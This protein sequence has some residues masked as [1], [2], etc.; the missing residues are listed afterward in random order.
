MKELI[1]LRKPREKH[2][3]NEDGTITLNMYDEDIHYKKGNEYVEIDNNLIESNNKVVNKENDFKVEFSKDKFLVNITEEENY[4]NIS[5]NDEYHLNDI[6][7]KDNSIIYKN[8]LS[9]I[10]IKYDIVGKTAKETIIVNEQISNFSKVNFLINTNLEL[11]E[12]ENNI[13]AL[14]GNK[15]IVYKFVPPYMIDDKQVFYKCTYNLEKLDNGYLLSLILDEEWLNNASYPVLIDPTIMGETSGVYDTYIYSGD[16]SVD[17]NSQEYLKI[18]VD[19]NNVKYRALVKFDLPIIGTGS[20]VISAIACFNSYKNDYYAVGTDLTSI[21]KKATVHQV[22]QSWDESS[23]NWNTMSEK[24]NSTVENYLELRRGILTYDT[25][26]KGTVTLTQNEVDITNLVKKWYSGVA[27]YGIMLKWLNE[28]KDSNCKEYYLYSKDNKAVSSNILTTDPKPF[29]VIQ[30]RNQTGILDY[31]TYDTVGLTAGSSNVNNYNGNV[32][33]TFTVNETVGGNNPLKLGLVYNTNDVILNND[34]NIALGFKINYDERLTLKT[35]N[36]ENDYIEYLAGDG[37]INYFYLDT[38]DDTYK[39]EDGL[40]LTI[41]KEED[42]YLMEDKNGNKYYFKLNDNIYYL[43]QVVLTNDNTL[44]IIR[45]IN[46]RV[47]EIQNN[48]DDRIAITYGDNK[49]EFESSNEHTYVTLENNKIKTICINSGTI[50]INYND[51]NIISEIIDVTNLKVSYQYYDTI[52]YRLM[53]ITQYGLNNEEGKSKT[54]E[55][56]FNATTITNNTNQKM[57]F[58]FN[59]LGNTIGTVL[60]S[61]D[62]TLKNSYGFSENYVNELK[63]ND[64]NK[65]IESSVPIKYGENLIKNGNFET[66]EDNGFITLRENVMARS[67]NYAALIDQS[68]YGEIVGSFCQDEEYVFSAYFKNATK[69]EINLSGTTFDKTVLLNNKIILPNDDYTRYEIPFSIPEEYMS[70]ISI[71]IFVDDNGVAYMDDIQLEKGTVAS[72]FN[73]LEN[74]NFENNLNGWNV[75]SYNPEDE[76][77]LQNPCEVV[78]LDSGEKAL[79]FNSNPDYSVI[80]RK[81]LNMNGKKGDTYTL[82]FWYKNEGVLDTDL[83]FIGNMATVS[84]YDSTKDEL[85]SEDGYGT[86]NVTLNYHADEWQFFTETFIATSDYDTVDLTIFSIYEANNLLVTNMSLVKNLGSYY[87]VYDEDGNIISSSD[88]ANNKI[89]YKYDTN[90]QLISMFNPKGNNYKYEYDNVIT[91]RL[92]RGISP[93]G[94]SNEIEYDLFGNPIKTIINNVSANSDTNVFYIR[95]KGTKKYLTPNME[96]NLLEI[97]DF[98][99]NRYAFK[100]INS[101]D[102]YMLFL[103]SLSDYCV[104]DINDKLMVVKNG[105]AIIFNIINN[106]NGSIS[107]KVK[108]QELYLTVSDNELILAEKTTDDYN[109]EFYLEDVDSELRIEETA[110]Y[111][112]DGKFIDRVID[113]LGNKVIYDVDDSTGLVKSITNAKGKKTTYEYTDKKQIKS[114][115]NDNKRVDYTY[116]NNLLSSIE[117]GNKKYTFTYD[118]FLNQKDVKINDSLLSSNT[119][120]INNGNL[121]EKKYGNNTSIKYEYDNFNRLCRF[122]KSNAVYDYFY[123]SFGMLARV[124]DTEYLYDYANRLSQFLIDNIFRVK[125]DYDNNGNINSKK[126]TLNLDNHSIEYTF[127]E[128]DSII[129]VTIDSDTINNDYDYLGRLRRKS[130]NDNLINEYTYKTN[131]DKTSLVVDTVKINDDVYKYTYDNLYNIEK[132]TL[133]NQVINE[134]KY[135]NRSQL[136]EDINYVLGYKYILSY[137]NEGNI[138]RKDTYNVSTGELVNTDVYEYDNTNWEDQLTKFNGEEITYDTIG[139]P[140]TIGSKNLTWTNGRELTSIDDKIKYYYNEDGIRVRKL[141]DNTETK[142]YLEGTQII[143]EVRGNNTIYYM[144]DEGI[145]LI[146]LVFNGVKYYYKRNNQNDIIGIYDSNYNEIVKYEYDCYGKVI[147]IKDENENEIIDTNNIGIINPFRYRGYYYD[148]ETGYY[149]LNSRYYNPEW[150]RFINADNFITD[151]AGSTRYNMYHYCNNN[152]IMYIDPDGHAVF[153]GLLITIA[154]VGTGVAI[155]AYISSKHTKSGNEKAKQEINDVQEK[156]KDATNIVPEN[157]VRKQMRKNAAEITKSTKYNSSLIKLEKFIYGVKD[158]GKYDL[159]TKDEWSDKVFEFQGMILEPQDFGNLNFGY[160]GRAMGYDLT[161]LQFG[162]GMYQLW[163]HGSSTL[164]D[165]ITPSFCDDPRD[166]YFIKMGALA[167]DAEHGQ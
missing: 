48:Y 9:N 22:T 112:D 117:T 118:N 98:V 138:L 145:N 11:V 127:N 105:T 67:G 33:N 154:V 80:V 35:I 72:P 55:Y 73:L 100:L 18:G 46:N 63:Q 136:I 161:F 79:Q 102:D 64:T 109:C 41:K 133:N 81:S 128:D 45:D 152:P 1:D 36:T 38:D 62:N 28:T 4:I 150:G 149:Y 163:D 13:V 113:A 83:E 94:I 69:L 137:D 115:F 104:C 160:I 124:N 54:Y 116:E 10:D 25:D 51:N 157:E 123:N 110:V 30:Y 166:A 147:S 82:S 108:D 87:Y 58:T 78:T 8:I 77:T 2:F 97:K 49:I 17:R 71:E 155:G 21:N 120:D 59:N 15:N 31:M 143:Y 65:P 148:N 126:Q 131:G 144:R 159:K 75:S 84:F 26:A 95:V 103:N 162:A 52:P 92:L 130:I 119:Y 151:N 93:T 70:Y 14:D 99:C 32:V 142:Y 158:N 76:T 39:S 111:S 135:D 89:E 16:T 5:L 47:I 107:L 56:S 20:Q 6:I 27:N 106:V 37:G 53:K 66:N 19:S 165:C 121:L 34:Y 12:K 114:I 90:N 91:D 44:S 50:Q 139:N 68:A 60:L 141:V 42:D 29:L 40:G 88:L 96:S 23:A 61:D 122:T 43:Y 125:Y 132:V 7:Y 140:L 164:Y 146:G 24:Y 74:S 129:K 167:Y 86:F 101:A 3:L 57:R 156:Q 85:T 134:Y 153:I